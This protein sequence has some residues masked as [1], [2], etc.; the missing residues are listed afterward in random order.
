MCVIV[1]KP[2][3]EKIEFDNINKCYQA[4]PDL[5]G[6]AIR[7]PKTNH[8]EIHRGLELHELYQC[9]PLDLESVE[10][11]FHFRIATSGNVNI[12]NSH[13]FPVIKRAAQSKTH[14]DIKHINASS[15]ITHNGIILTKAEAAEHNQHLSD[16]ALLARA[17][18]TMPTKSRLVILEM[19]AGYSNKFT[20]TDSKGTTLFGKFHEVDGC[21]YSNLNWKYQTKVY[22]YQADDKADDKDYNH[23]KEFDWN[24]YQSNYKYSLD[25]R[26]NE[27]NRQLYV[28][29]EKEYGICLECMLL[30]GDI[31]AQD[32]DRIIAE[33]YEEYY[34]RGKRK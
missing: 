18:A 21:Y 24:T 4:N 26:C 2:I 15:A 11:V 34:T 16:T 29:L 7:D 17:L 30:F 28:T 19:L 6:I 10:V 22:T 23:W 8:V 1:V 20:Y 25:P 9:L 27:C 32:Y 13:P 3:G 12:I 14:L 31:S 5:C 33:E